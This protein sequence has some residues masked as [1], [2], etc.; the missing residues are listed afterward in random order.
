MWRGQACQLGLGC[1]DMELRP[2]NA[3]VSPLSY[4]LP[5]VSHSP[6]AQM[7]VL[8]VSSLRLVA[9]LREEFSPGESGWAG[10]S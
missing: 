7:S 8:W 10:R 9:L 3:F 4:T 6:G 1:L 2:G 5:S